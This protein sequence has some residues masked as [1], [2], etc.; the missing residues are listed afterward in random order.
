[1]SKPRKK[2]KSPKRVLALPDLE[3]A[4]STVLNTLTSVSVQ[5]TYDQARRGSEQ[6]H[7]TN[8]LMAR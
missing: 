1:M 4:K 8:S 6:Y 2:K 7:S 3:Q 5:R